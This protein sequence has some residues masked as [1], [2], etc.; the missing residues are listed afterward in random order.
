MKDI[1]QQRKS[2]KTP[3]PWKKEQS[4]EEHADSYGR[5]LIDIDRRKNDNNQE[6]ADDKFNQ[7]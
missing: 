2:K 4:E 1:L 3:S 7:W 5:I 6:D